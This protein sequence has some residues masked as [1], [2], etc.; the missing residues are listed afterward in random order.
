[1]QKK[2]IALAIAGL[3]SAAFAQS[4]VTL[5]GLV[6]VGFYSQSIQTAGVADTKTFA[7]SNGS[8]TSALFVTATE[9]LGG[10]NKVKFFGET[11]WAPAGNA[12]VLLNSYNYLEIAGNWGALRGGNLNTDTLYATIGSQPFGTGIG[13]GISGA[14]GRLSRGGSNGTF[15]AGTAGLS[16]DGEV[17][18]ATG[19]IAGARSVRVNNSVQYSTPSMGGFSGSLQLAKQNNDSTVAAAGTTAGFQSLGLKYNN[20]PINVYYA[21]EQIKAG[22]VAAPANAAALAADEKVTHNVLSGNYTFGPATVYA[23]WTSSKSSVAAV[24]DGRSWNLALKYAV[25]GALSL[26]ANYVSVDDKLVGD[27]DRRLTAVGLDYALS[28]RSTAYGRYETGDNDRSGGTGNGIG[29]FNRW[30]AGL[31]HSF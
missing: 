15:G 27:K 6:D 13:S 11:D 31:R 9:D 21:N 22:S 3:S 25:S 10:G 19:T 20:G 17:V 1:M 2:I 4:T 12:S 14:F 23:G 24:A 8:S 30:Q 28:K 5:S 18:A 7:A 16:V 29:G 26:A